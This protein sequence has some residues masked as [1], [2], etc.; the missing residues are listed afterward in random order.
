MDVFIHSIYEKKSSLRQLSELFS[1]R[2]RL[3]FGNVRNY[4]N[5]QKVREAK[6]QKRKTIFE[7]FIFV[8]FERIHLKK[9][10]NVLCKRLEMLT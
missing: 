10:T 7:D 5:L 3:L 6:L 2:S 8:Y 9:S 1:K 4:S